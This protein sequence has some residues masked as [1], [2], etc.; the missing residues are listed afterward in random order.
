MFGTAKLSHLI[1]CLHCER[2][3]TRLQWELNADM[4]PTPGC[5]GFVMGDGF[6]WEEVRAGREDRYPAK[7]EKGKVYPLY[8]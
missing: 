6:N 8:E 7:P 3:H 1:W 2:V 4:C 5:D